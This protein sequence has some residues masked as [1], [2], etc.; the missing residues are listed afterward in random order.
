M[1]WQCRWRLRDDCAAR[2]SAIFAARARRRCAALS[3]ACATAAPP[4][5]HRQVTIYK[6]GSTTKFKIRCSKYLYTRC[7]KDSEKAKKLESSLP[8]G[9][10]KIEKGSRTKA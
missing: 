6:S 4:L 1:P 8:P 9:L 3:A 2:T 10:T 5:P 7:E